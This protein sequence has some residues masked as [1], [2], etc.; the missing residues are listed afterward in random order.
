MITLVSLSFRASNNYQVKKLW[1]NSPFLVMIFKLSCLLAE[2]CVSADVE[3]LDHSHQQHFEGGLH[4]K[5]FDHEAILGK[6]YTTVLLLKLLVIH[7]N[8]T[9]WNH[10]SMLLDYFQQQIFLGAVS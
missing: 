7:S 9:S 1:E 2:A 8:A 3:T 10:N 4:N 6:V 5:E